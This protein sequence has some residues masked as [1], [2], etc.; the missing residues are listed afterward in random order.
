MF[1]SPRAGTWAPTGH[2]ASSEEKKRGRY[3][4][5][6]DVDFDGDDLFV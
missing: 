2:W 1:E 5:Q 3:G 4:S 6:S